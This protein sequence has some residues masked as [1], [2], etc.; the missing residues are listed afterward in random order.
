[1]RATAQK[2][3][4]VYAMLSPLMVGLLATCAL[5]SQGCALADSFSDAI[6]ADTVSPSQDMRGQQSD[7][8]LQDMSP[9]LKD[10]PCNACAQG[11]L[12]TATQAQSVFCLSGAKV[13]S[14][15]VDDFI[16]RCAVTTP[17]T[18]TPPAR[19]LLNAWPN[20]LKNDQSTLLAAH[21]SD[22]NK[23]S[24]YEATF[25]KDLDFPIDFKQLQII[26]QDSFEIAHVSHLG[27]PAGGVL[28]LGYDKDDD[29]L[30]VQVVGVSLLADDLPQERFT[31]CPGAPAA[32]AYNLTPGNKADET[33]LII[34]G[35]FVQPDNSCA[36]ESVLW[37]DLTRS[38]SA[39][40]RNPI[41]DKIPQ[42]PV[43]LSRTTGSPLLVVSYISDK[44]TTPRIYNFALGEDGA[45]EGL[46][47]QVTT[48][49]YTNTSPGTNSCTL[50][51]QGDA[52]LALPPKRIYSALLTQNMGNA[53]VFI[54]SFELTEGP[55]V[56]TLIGNLQNNS[57]QRRCLF[58]NNTPRRQS[59]AVDV[60]RTPSQQDANA[61][62]L[63]HT[64]EENSPSF[65]VA[66]LVSIN[67]VNGT[68]PTT[69]TILNM[70]LGLEGY[71]FEPLR[72]HAT[73]DQDKLSLLGFI[74]K[75]QERQLIALR[76]NTRGELF[77]QEPTN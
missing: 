61:L 51:E 23:A 60:F 74:T 49:G 2:S 34:A 29:R 35:A 76:F 24:V 8:G 6:Y 40:P 59:V 62:L 27:G 14:A 4:P 9:D 12:R 10:D 33:K 69:G 36:F 57:P 20:A 11:C 28:L 47:E 45:V 75:D 58:D 73:P 30:R 26:G 3:S 54:S 32:V 68:A 5:S 46:G 77:C 64:K 42:G 55:G 38:P 70:R 25:D 22:D 17:A 52:K 72:L 41:S 53:P 48:L 7:D 65:D 43:T 1:M 21:Y 31:R 56:Q 37:S 18:A 15:Q 66:E 44:E 67:S 71:T 19:A 63:L 50:I 13:I 16:K 39:L